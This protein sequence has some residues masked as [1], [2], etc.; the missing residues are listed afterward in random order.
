MKVIF[1][2]TFPLKF[3]YL[4]NDVR[5]RVNAS[6]LKKTITSRTILIPGIF[7]VL[8]VNA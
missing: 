3:V 8:F 5:K 7:R 6:P 1:L 2:V 4:I